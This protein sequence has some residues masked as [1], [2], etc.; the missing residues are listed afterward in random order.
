[1]SAKHWLR[2]PLLLVFLV[3]TPSVLR[4]DIIS[5]SVGGPGGSGVGVA[6][7]NA[8]DAIVE[9]TFETIDY[10][11]I[12]V[13]VDEPGDYFF[14][15]G[16]EAGF[17][18]NDTNYDW[19]DFHFHLIPSEPQDGLEFFLAESD[20]FSNIILMEDSIWMLDGVIPI[21]GFGAFL[22]GV[23]VGTQVPFSNDEFTFVIQQIP[24]I[25]PEPGTLSLLGVGALGLVGHG[26]RRRRRRH[27]RE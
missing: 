15:E 20:D 22:L 24:S 6:P 12:Q 2:L 17:V 11:N 1:M 23:R 5:I 9:K 26:W 10:I 21:G 16:N 3:S 4:A 13:T 14:D 8:F 27:R 7:G 19:V 25:V 18:F